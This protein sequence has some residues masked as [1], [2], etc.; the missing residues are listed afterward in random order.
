MVLKRAAALVYTL[1]FLRL[2]TTK[3]EDTGA[4]KE[5]IIDAKG[6]RDRNV[7]LNTPAKKNAYTTFHR[8]VFN[9]K[10]IINKSGSE[11]FASYAS[12]LYLIKE[13]VQIDRVL[14]GL[15]TSKSEFINENSQWF[16][17]EDGTL[18][19]GIYKLR[20]DKVLAET[21]DDIVFEKDKI[22]IIDGRPID[23]VLGVDIY[24][25]THLKTNKIVYVAV[26][27]LIK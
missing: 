10:R 22:R 11:K 4:Y 15:G 27:E 9:L 16:M 13:H 8:L 3:F 6:K 14:K 2:L 23:V 25:A 20:S 24:E 26:G 18:A 7:K 17:L 1:R 12:A 19:P 21:Y 5:G